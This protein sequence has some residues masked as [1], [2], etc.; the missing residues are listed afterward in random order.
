MKEWLAFGL[1]MIP[2]DCR[3]LACTRSNILEYF[4]TVLC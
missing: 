1:L 4:V 2:M 3:D